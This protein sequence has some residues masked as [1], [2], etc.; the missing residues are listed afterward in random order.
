[1]RSKFK[2]ISGYVGEEGHE[3]EAFDHVHAAEIYAEWEDSMTAEYSIM[4]G[5]L[6]D[7]TVVDPDGVTKHFVVSGGAIPVY[8]AREK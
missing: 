7:V 4:G 3:I 5:S 8:E 6:E 1:M 2:V